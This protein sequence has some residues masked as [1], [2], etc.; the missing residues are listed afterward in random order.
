MLRLKSK[1]AVVGMGLL[2]WMILGA[3]EGAS[4]TLQLVSAKPGLYD[5]KTGRSVTLGHPLPTKPEGVDSP[6]LLSGTATGTGRALVILVEFP[7]HGADVSHT[8]SVYSQ[9]L[10]STDT[11][12][13]GSMNDYYREV[14][15]GTF[16]VTGDVTR[17][18][19]APQPYSFYVSGSYGFGPYPNNA[20]KMVEH[21]VALADPD[22]DFSLYDTDGDGYVDALFVIHAGPG[23]EETGSAN[24]IWSHAWG[25]RTPIAVDG[26][27][28]WPYSMEP[29]EHDSGN[30]ISIGVFCHEFGHILGLPDLYDIDYSSDGV[31][32]Y[33]LMGSGS[34]GADGRSP[35][36][37]AHPCAW[38]KIQL[39]WI[40]P[41][42]VTTDLFNRPIRS[43]EGTPEVYRLW[44]NGNSGSEYF[45]VSNR[46]RTGFDSLLPG[47]GVLIWHIDET[48][49]NNSDE[50]HKLVDLEQ[51][52]G[53]NQLDVY[54]DYNRGDAG[55]FFPGTTGNRSFDRDS[56]PNSRDYEGSP[57][58]VAVRNI[59][60]SASVMAADLEVTGTPYP[61]ILASTTSH[62]FGNTNVGESSAWVLTIYN[63]GTGDLT[64]NTI[65]SN[66]S[67]FT[68]ASPSFPQQITSGSSMAVS[69]TFSPQSGG[70]KSGQ[71]TVSSDDPDESILHIA[72]SGYGDA[73]SASPDI[74]LPETNHDFGSLLVGEQVDWTLSV[75]N[76]GSANLLISSVQSDCEDF[77]VASPTFPSTI[78][79][80]ATVS[81][82][83]SFKPSTAGVRA[84]HLTVLSND[85]DEGS[86]AVNVTGTGLAPQI[87]VS[88]S[89]IEKTLPG[90]DTVAVELSIDNQGNYP[91]SF[92]IGE[93]AN[94]LFLTPI[95]GT[96]GANQTTKVT[97]ILKSG[98]L[99][100]GEYAAEITIFS[101]DPE[102]GSVLVPVSMV[103]ET[104]RIRVGSPVTY[105]FPGDTALIDI[106]MDNWT[107]RPVPVCGLQAEV[108]FD[109]AVFT[110]VEITPTERSQN[111]NSF[112]WS[113]PEPGRLILLISDTNH[114][115]IPTGTGSI[116]RIRFATSE[117]P[118]LGQSYRIEFEKVILADEGGKALP[119]TSLDGLIIIG[120]KGDINRDGTINVIDLIY[121][122]N[123]ILGSVNPTEGEMWA[124]D[125]NGDGAIDIIDVVDMVNHICSTSPPTAKGSPASA[126]LTVERMISLR[127]GQPA[128]P[129]S[130]SHGDGIAGVQMEIVY[131]PELFTPRD[132]IPADRCR[133]MRVE[134][135]DWNGLITALMFAPKGEAIP[136]GHGPVLYLTGEEE[137]SYELS[138]AARIQY[139]V[140]VN[141]NGN[142]IPVENIG[143][144]V[145]PE[146][147]VPDGFTLGQNYPNPFNSA[148]TIRYSIPGIKQRAES[149]GRGEDSELY[150]L[151]TTLKIYNIL[152]QEVKTL[153]D[154][155]QGPGYYTVTWNGRDSS[156]RELPS[157]VYFYRLEAGVFT[158]T[159][160]MLLVK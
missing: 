18:Y 21:A 132:L 45:L 16:G 130:I 102:N 63:G 76:L 153:V 113:S 131:N 103:V 157:G 95:S 72:V 128:L 71:L 40:T 133:C 99:S 155:P 19:T 160:R 12:P 41:T 104:S 125:F 54:G 82:I 74:V 105:A 75:H 145:E 127:T 115:T 121:V 35:H 10:F 116:A 152:G 87:G 48:A 158:D 117:G 142:A 46:Q 146:A 1:V 98:S 61:D 27:T 94:W 57:T 36:R 148:T 28:V 144:S 123:I 100:E 58:G 29:E 107:E 96:V 110:P 33:C 47:S 52:D 154:E 134:W 20:Q 114:H 111:M 85:V 53:L 129:I 86:I 62:D 37:P 14:S 73:P 64:V 11:Y 7:D 118:E 44:T 26:V 149:E 55:D 15:Y 97:A 91:L 25:T 93:M 80:N 143:A 30:I 77:E 84:G 120:S 68:I 89:H 59:S 78:S 112:V 51:A 43:I 65:I 3:A 4:R 79:P 126:E 141:R 137:D 124:A 23:A 159:K 38:S 108:H 22:V 6:Q 122:V 101:N 32:F 88:P 66:H 49:Q 69:V 136:S 119:I 5:Q 140:L 13:T 24:H 2:F 39:G 67:D 56:N 81:V 147:E 92:E 109:G 138:P 34:W 106:E 150:A 50:T 135:K 156:G 8:P 70:H 17:W 9:M 31:G 90:E 139:V 83:I 60:N 42:W 151:R